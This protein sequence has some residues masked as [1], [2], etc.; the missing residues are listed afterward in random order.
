[1]LETAFSLLCIL[2]AAEKT[3]LPNKGARLYRNSDAPP[4][5]VRRA[6][7]TCL[8]TRGLISPRVLIC[9]C[10]R[11]R[12]FLSTKKPPCGGT[13]PAKVLYP[14]G[15]S[16]S[17]HKHV[18]AIVQ[19]TKNAVNPTLE[20]GE[21][22]RSHRLRGFSVSMPPISPKTYGDPCEQALKQ[23]YQYTGRQRL[24]RRG[25]TKDQARARTP[26]RFQ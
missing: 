14:L 6:E 11:S 4:R 7:F 3:P 26:P 24:C 16:F 21:N 9:N 1:M 8:C 20:C 25:Q 22:P 15:D 17:S 12:V 10:Q 2:G 18:A 23:L 13:E 19:E 5:A